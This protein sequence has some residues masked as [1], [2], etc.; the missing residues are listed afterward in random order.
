MSGSSKD[1][2]RAEEF[3]R[4]TAGALRALAE[5][6]DVQVNFQPG[7]SGVSGKRAR[8]PLPTRALPAPEMTK[9]R[10]A[11]DAI[12]LRLRHHD[13]AVHSARMPARR[14]A[15]DAYDALEQARVEIVGSRHMAGV[16]ANLRS[17]LTEECEAEGYDRMSRKDQLPVAA[18]LALLAREH[19]SGEPVPEPARRVL[20]LWRGTLGEGAEAALA[21]LGRT[22]ADQRAFT[23]AARK[24][25]AALELAEAEADAE[26]EEQTEEGE[27]G[28]EFEPAGQPARGRRPVRIGHREHGR[29][30]ARRDAGRGG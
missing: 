1:N 25:L 2:T 27:E 16:S 10:G 4:A 28:G 21:E 30:P 11:S 18:A 15:K 8:L 17:K 26:P 20:D 23:R 5:Q 22:Q 29:R 3:K 24:L 19:M 13:D 6:P 7:P 9:L 14:E 12:A